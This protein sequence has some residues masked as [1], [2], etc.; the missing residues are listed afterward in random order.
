MSTSARKTLKIG[1]IPADGIGREVIPV[2]PFF[3][4]LCSAVSLKGTH[5]AAKAAIVAL[6]SDIPTPEFIDLAAGWETFTRTGNALPHETVEYVSWKQE[7][8]TESLIL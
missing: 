1:L 8:V 4:L 7:V 6:G 5:Q 2:R 3:I